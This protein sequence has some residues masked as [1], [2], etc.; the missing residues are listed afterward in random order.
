MK[1]AT[2][3]FVAILVIA[4]AGPLAAQTS[5][6]GYSDTTSKNMNQPSTTTTTGERN[7]TSTSTRS[8]MNNTNT[9]T[10]SSTTNEHLPRTAGPMPIVGVGGLAALATS[11]WLKRR[12]RSS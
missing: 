11:L 7:E 6:P 3:S 8:D 5:S 10:E 2:T 1:R 12:R 4:L 9:S